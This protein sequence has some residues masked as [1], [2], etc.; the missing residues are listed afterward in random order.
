MPPACQA[1]TPDTDISHL[2]M[3]C[4][5][6]FSPARPLRAQGVLSKDRVRQVHP[7]EDF[8][9]KCWEA[10]FSPHQ[11]AGP[12]P[13]IWSLPFSHLKHPHWGQERSKA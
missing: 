2:C 9:L 13:T 10:Y 12:L 5:D 3:K 7:G 8:L 6:I 11:A 1:T 4:P